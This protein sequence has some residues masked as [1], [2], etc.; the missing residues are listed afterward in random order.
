MCQETADFGKQNNLVLGYGHLEVDEF[1]TVATITSLF[2]EGDHKT[3]DR[4]RTHDIQRGKVCS[5]CCHLPRGKPLSGLCCF[6]LNIA[7]EGLMRV[8]F[9]FAKPQCNL[10]LAGGGNAP[11]LTSR[12]YT[13]SLLFPQLKA[14]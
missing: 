4:V 7:S 5:S 3:T 13:S 11:P 14:P 8:K 10:A 1:G 6:P 12:D 9:L 2:T